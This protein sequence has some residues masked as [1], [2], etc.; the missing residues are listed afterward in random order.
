MLRFCSLGS[1]SSGN[2]TLVEA[3]APG[4]GPTVRLLIDC[5]LSL[6]ELTRRLA[7]R[8]CT[9]AEIDAV[10]VTHEHGDHIGCV[11]ALVRKHRTTV[12]M[13]E[14]TWR[15]FAKEHD[16]PPTL[17]YARDGEPI[18]LR[19][20]ALQVR[21]YT[22]PHDAREPLQ[23]TVSDGRHR[24][25]VLTDAGIDTPR[26]VAELQGC[27][28]LLLEANHDLEML[29]KGPYPWPL[30]RRIAGPH[31]HLSNLTA[32][33]ILGQ[34]RHAGLK[35]VVAAHLSEQNNKPELATAALAQALGTVNEDIVVASQ[36][37]GSN[38]LDLH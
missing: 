24:L 36:R 16:P 23:L 26:I 1:G 30:K 7:L 32:A 17:H 3:A 31:G 22:V 27:T 14:G 35:H 20:G 8:G 21:P 19:G 29:E 28:A 4:G 11:T 5:G 37:D 34:C 9:P 18:E 15:G 10:F 13:S 2:A 38:W 6:R 33:A 12:Y 25:G